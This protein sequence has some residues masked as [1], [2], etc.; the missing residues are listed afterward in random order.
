MQGSFTEAEYQQTIIQLFSQELGYEYRSAGDLNRLNKA[1]VV[2]W[3]TLQQKLTEL[4][5]N[6]HADAIGEAIRKIKHMDK[7]ELIARNKDFHHY[8]ANGIDVSYFDDGEKSTHIRLLNTE[9]PTQNHFMITD[10]FTVIGKEN[11]RADIVVFINGFPLVVMELKSCMHENVTMEHAYNQLRNYMQIIPDLFTYNTFN[12]ISNMVETRAGTLTADF[13]RYMQWKSTNGEDFDRHGNNYETF[14][15]GIF[16]KERLINIISNYMIFMN[17][18]NNSTKILAAYHQFF[19]VEKAVK[20]TINAPNNQG[21]AGV[22][23]HTQGSGKSYSMVFYTK[24]L[25]QKLKTPTL[26]LLTDRNDLDEQLFTTFSN[27]KDYLRQKPVKINNRQNLKE[28]LYNRQASGIFFSTMQKFEE[29]TGLLSDRDDIIVIADEAHRSQYGLEEKLNKETGEI[30]YGFAHHVKQ[31]FPHASYIG[32]TGTPIDNADRSTRDVF[33]DYIDIYDM[34]KAVEDG[35]TKSIYYES[36]VVNL[37]L[38]QDILE[39]IDQKYDELS[40]TAE[41]YHIAQSKKDLGKMDSL[42]GANETITDLCKDIIQHYEERKD[43]VKGKAMI[44]AY[45]RKIGVKIYEKILELYPDY[46]DKLALVMTNS[47]KDPEHW[48]K[49]VGSKKQIDDVAL[50]FKNPDGAIK[51]VIVV[52]M[53]LTGFDVPALD[54]MYIFKPMKS[55]TL[56]QA[57]ARV[58]R[59]FGDKEAGL[60]VDYIGIAAALR[61]ALQEYTK[62]DQ[63]NFANNDIKDTAYKEFKDRL[64][65]CIDLLH[66]IDIKGFFEDEPQKRAV[67]I[68]TSINFLLNDEERKNSFIEQAVIVKKMY[69]IC[70][71][72]VQKNERLTSVF[73]EA[74]RSS[75]T[76]IVGDG[77]TSPKEINQ[78]ISTLLKQA[79]DSEGVVSVFDDLPEFSLFDPAYLTQIKQ[80]KEKNIAAEILRKA[81]AGELSSMK[82]SNHVKGEEFSEKL[83]KLMNQYRNGLITNVEVIEE[84]RKIAE[85]IQMHKNQ[86]QSLGLSPEEIAFYD[87][88]CKPE[89]IMDFYTNDALIA[90]TKELTDEINRNKTIDWQL[91]EQSRSKMK[92]MVKRL[93]K[94]HDYPPDDMKNAIEVVLKQAELVADHIA[95]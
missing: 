83:N 54:T 56:M 90:L 48:A 33:G 80:M 88:I 52:D 11:K 7:I 34:T 58:N 51:I 91:K 14:F 76:Q 50:E 72:L 93:L 22:V 4:N 82:K 65:N 40:Q 66:S 19:A 12:V 60:V 35:A 61:Q 86:T 92:R 46:K 28:K 74:I 70:R 87:A 84:I 37:S 18:G 26:V 94:K 78:Q 73:C 27:A 42:L 41:P 2:Q 68:R 32:F 79:V 15:K 16:P 24:R 85:E 30:T 23:W 36:R 95:S 5:P 31:A 55:H 39:K 44:V 21:K 29:Q 49:Y 45:S 25:I 17:D 53:W 75:L 13:E 57:I 3:D 20:A 62:D 8:L 81:L 9:E 47:N 43:V 69:G 64:N 1:E 89:N 6:A 63:E 38:N 10:E 67:A 59:V 71:S 77:K